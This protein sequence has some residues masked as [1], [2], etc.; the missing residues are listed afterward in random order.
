MELSA[1]AGRG[2]DPMRVIKS[3]QKIQDQEQYPGNSLVRGE[4]QGKRGED[5]SARERQ[6]QCSYPTPFREMKDT[7]R[8]VGAVQPSQHSGQSCDLPSSMNT[9][10]MNRDGGFH[11][12]A[13]EPNSWDIQERYSRSLGASDFSSDGSRVSSCQ[14]AT[15]S[16]GSAGSAVD[17]RG[18][19]RSRWEAFA[20]TTG[21]RNTFEP[22]AQ[23]RQVR[24]GIQFK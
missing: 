10:T 23:N 14:G 4:D 17:T 13:A 12:G 11:V 24:L 15:G 20:S 5:Y 22:E 3:S 21:T 7:T 18:C 6:Q 1:T 9:C 2:D 8:G 16:G 19:R